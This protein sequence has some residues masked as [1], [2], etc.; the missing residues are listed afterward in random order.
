MNMAFHPDGRAVLISNHDEGTIAV[1][2]LECAEISRSLPAG[3]A[4]RRF[5]SSD[6]TSRDRSHC[7]AAI[8]QSQ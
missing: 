8:G 6:L 2:D 4:S 5:R 3:L 7:L 1:V